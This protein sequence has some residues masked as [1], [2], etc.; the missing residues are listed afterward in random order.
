MAA[1]AASHE[2]SVMR[3]FPAA[4][5]GIALLAVVAST[6]CRPTPSA[7]EGPAAA[8]STRLRRDVA[9]LADDAR[10]GRGT[11]TAGNAAA[12]DYIAQRFA[13]LG[14]KPAS[15]V[16][17]AAPT[18]FTG[19]SQ[20]F[21]ARSISRQRAG[22]PFELPARNLVAVVPGRDAALAG[23]YVV[24]GAHYDH[25]G[26]DTL[27]ALDP[28]AR[29]VVRNGADDN[30]SGTAA[31]LEL[32]R[33]VARAPLA[34][35]VVFVAFSGEELGLLGSQHFVSASPVPL[36]SVTA[37]LNFD[38]VGRFDRN[39]LQVFGTATATEFPALLAQLNT[40]AGFALTATGDGFG[41]SDHASFYG[42]DIPVLHF[43]TGTHADYHRASD[44]ADRFNAAGAARV[45]D[46]AMGVLRDV[47]N[48]PGRLTFQRTPEPVAQQ[49][50]AGRGAYLGSI[51]DMAA[52]DGTG[53]RLTGVR[54]GSP[55]EVGGLKADDIIVEF[56]GKPVKDLYAYT[57]AIAA[58]APG[59]TVKVVVKRS[60]TLVPLTIV[61]GRRGN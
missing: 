46:F 26:R 12:G 25:L 19:W 20:P 31:V 56:G 44:D 49:P 58:Y 18:C 43:F 42:K 50:R 37:M 28:D 61:L 36:T 6:A 17:G 40:S 35:T 27:G 21:T 29:D 59:D 41:R 57:D 5:R 52:G 34:R 9:W 2:I 14:V 11:G 38:M 4:L 3:P 48:R 24:V 30:A 51:P 55:A 22:L 15:T 53:L 39:Q 8:D 7:L 60:G 33:L 13:A 16:C 23:E 45:V 47:G 10:D 32:A 1:A 54:G